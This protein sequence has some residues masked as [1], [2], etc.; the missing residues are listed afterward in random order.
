VALHAVRPMLGQLLQQVREL[1]GLS[2]RRA[3]EAFK[4][5]ARIATLSYCEVSA[6][7]VDA[8]LPSRSASRLRSV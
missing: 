6:W 4:L 3:A 7:L 2:L 1:Q 5:G 8:L